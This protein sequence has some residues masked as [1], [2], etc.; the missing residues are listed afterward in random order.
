MIS[1]GIRVFFAAAALSWQLT[2]DTTNAKT[3]Y[4]AKNIY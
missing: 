2:N 3:I 4:I 1:N